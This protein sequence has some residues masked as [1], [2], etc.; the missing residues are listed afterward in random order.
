[1]LIVSI[2][3]KQTTATHQLKNAVTSVAFSARAL[4][5]SSLCSSQ[6]DDSSVADSFSDLIVISLSNALLGMDANDPPKTIATMQLIGSIFSNVSLSF[7]FFLFVVK[8]MLC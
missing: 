6:S 2:V 8:I 1:M 3:F 4:L 5:L 7:Y